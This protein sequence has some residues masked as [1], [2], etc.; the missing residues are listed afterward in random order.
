MS[1]TTWLLDGNVLVA[2]TIPAHRDH[3]RALA[4]FGRTVKRLATCPITQGTLLRVSPK[5]AS[6][7]LPA[8]AMELLQKIISLPEHEF[9][10][11]SLSYEQVPMQHLLGS[12]QVTDA[13]LAALARENGGRVATFDQGFAQLH[14]DVVTLIPT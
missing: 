5:Y 6:E 11:D 14:P 4:W 1:A 9:W 8:G 12:A 7:L 2:L 3:Q 13:Y 10:P